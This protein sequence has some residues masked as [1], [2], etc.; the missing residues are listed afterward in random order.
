MGMD[1]ERQ[2]KATARSAPWAM[3]LRCVVGFGVLCWGASPAAASHY[4]LEDLER[5][6]EDELAKLK[7]V[8]VETTEQFL[9][10]ALTKEG[11]AGLTRSTSMS[12]GDVLAFAVTCE[13]LQVQGVGPKVAKMMHAAGVMG[14][15]DLAGREAGALL[16]RLK[17]AN[18][19][20]KYVYADPP[21]ELVRG[22]IERAA[23]TPH[24]VK[25]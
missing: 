11:R 7:R 24:R 5:F 22:W 4:F 21:V 17:V 2:A 15:D 20:K 1:M 8:G 10:T 18:E 12:E 19:G 25:R 23:Q 6:S 14:V 16:E 9:V 13:L 3:A